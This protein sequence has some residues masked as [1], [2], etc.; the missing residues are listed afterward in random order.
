[1]D[2]HALEQEVA[3]VHHLLSL[4]E[5]KHRDASDALRLQQ[6]KDYPSRLA[7]LEAELAHVSATA[8]ALQT[9]N[10]ELKNKYEEFGAQVEAFMN[11]QSDAKAAAQAEA[12]ERVQR[13]QAQTDATRQQAT[14]ALAA[15]Q[16]DLVRVV[17]QLKLHQE[18][19]AKAEQTVQRLT[20]QLRVVEAQ[21]TDE[22]L[23]HATQ[24]RKLEKEAAHWKNEVA[25]E[26]T[27][28]VACE[29]NLADA[30]ARHESEV[31]RLHTSFE[32]QLLQRAKEK[33]AEAHTRWQNDFAAKQE[34][35]V[36]ALKAKYDA[37][38]A[39]Q[40]TELL[41][42]RQQALDAAAAI[43]AKHD[44]AKRL[45][46]ESDERERQRRLEAAAREKAASDDERARDSAYQRRQRELDTRET[47][48]AER[49]R[50]L[51][52][53]E[54]AEGRKRADELARRSASA[55]VRSTPSAAPSVVV[56]NL[57]T[58]D[59]TSQ[60]ELDQ[61]S[62]RSNSRGAVAVVT[63][64]TVRRSNPPRGASASSPLASVDW[65]PRAQHEAELHA[66][67]AQL[68]LAGE[69]KLR[70]ALQELQTRKEKEFRTA[71]VNVRKGIQ[72]LEAAVD[73][74]RKEKASVE[75][76]V[77]SERQA[78]V[79][80]KQELDS[81]KEA[82]LAVVQRLEEANDNVGKLR[83]L[84]NECETKCR[85]ADERATQARE[86]EATS[87]R[88]VGVS[89]AEIA[90]LR[91]EVS[92]LETL[93]Q[94]RESE[95]TAGRDEQA[96]LQSQVHALEADLQ[97]SRAELRT[98]T[99]AVADRATKKALTAVSR[100][101]SERKELADR[102][103]ATRSLLVAEKDNVRHLTS[104]IEELQRQRTVEDAAVEQL[105]RVGAQ[106]R[107]ELSN[108]TRV[109]KNF[110]DT[111]EK[112]V[113]SEVAERQRVE[114]LLRAAEKDVG[115]VQLHHQRVL[116]VYKMDL[117]KL[118]S[119]VLEM[120]AAVA[121]DVKRS[122]RQ[123]ER[124]VLTLSSSL[125]KQAALEREMRIREHERELESE[126]AKSDT[127]LQRKEQELSGVLGNARV[128]EQEKLAHTTEQVA[129]KTRQVSDLEAQLASEKTARVTLELALFKLE[130]DAA[131]FEA[132]QARLREQLSSSYTSSERMS[133]EAERQRGLLEQRARIS[134]VLQGFVV[135]LVKAHSLR[136][137]DLLLREIDA[138]W[139]AQYD[140]RQ[141]TIELDRVTELLHVER[142]R[143]I[144]QAR[145]DSAAS[146]EAELNAAK[147][148]MKALWATP[149]PSDDH[150]DSNE[151]ALP[152]YVAAYR[153]FHQLQADTAR[154]RVAWTSELDA[155]DARIQELRR[156][157]AKLQ[158]ATNVL[159]FEKETVVREMT[160]LT[161]TLSKKREHEV[162][163]LRLECE[164][165]VEQAKHAHETERMKADQEHKVR[166]ER[167]WR[168][169]GTHRCLDL[170]AVCCV[171]CVADHSRPAPKHPRGRTQELQRLEEPV[172]YLRTWSWRVGVSR[173][174]GRLLMDG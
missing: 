81:A 62:T 36:E 61:Q 103:S 17:D 70:V 75:L 138:S 68:V 20:E 162:D 122:L 22:K 27:R 149:D 150:N 18:A 71:M 79:A 169:R 25:K 21:G 144:A 33:E 86:A 117:S 142:Q 170:F 47:R 97:R 130:K 133:S 124:E 45:Q 106:Q 131:Q 161:Q 9:E 24:L 167:E 85:R 39:T 7:R 14:E 120:R 172:D 125:A 165:R 99:D 114:Q 74:A 123:L 109:H 137:P 1:M 92:A 151:L 164:R 66:R 11:E 145:G 72:K 148:A 89:H 31:A 83:R 41:S 65:V 153:A 50:V 67:E 108:L 96:R 88:Q 134:A 119:D 28:V 57:Q 156:R 132:E 73:D 110:A 35:R 171:R 40:Q 55:A 90:S 141:L 113:G 78:F 63:T 128:S 154:E 135:S 53:N 121:R 30:A 160:V 93:G 10:G 139:L 100:H 29:K 94:Q 157:K 52:E 140:E 159:R 15:K 16:S 155:R 64:N 112:R 43:T 34:A 58:P 3:H 91:S 77:Q 126:R 87:A 48:V 136:A 147:R 98:E 173:R 101:E 158:E 174:V 104:E 146:L 12:D 6:A 163:E 166:W 118:K 129:A 115:D 127:Q 23:H 38:L 26:K 80:L 76:E 54:H 51:L 37:A 69:E 111:M 107:T 42:A 116:R 152:W 19:L 84:V 13:V 60:Q 32:K 102:E 8:A 2:K 59:D 168:G 95:L 56:L 5:A 44:A 4:A 46:R 49:E 82:K 143:A 105:K